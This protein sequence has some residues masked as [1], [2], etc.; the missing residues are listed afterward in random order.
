[1]QAI[2]SFFIPNW[3]SDVRLDGKTAVI[4]GANTGIG[5]ETAKDLAARGARVILA[6]RDMAKA[7]QAAKE[8]MREVP[9]PKVVVRHLDLSDTKS[10]CQFAESIYNSEKALHYLINNAGVA[11]CPYSTT[12]DG[13]EM[14]FGVNHLGHFF[15]TF[16]LLDLLKY[17]APSRVINLSSIAHTM[18]RIRFDD[19]AGEKNYNPVGAYAQSKLANVLFT[20]ELAK[21]TEA[22]GVTVYSVDPGVVNT[23]IARHISKP[24]STVIGMVASMIK[25]SAEGAYT[26]I[27]CV[28]TPESQLHNGGHYKDCAYNKSCRAGQDDATALKLW[29]ASCHL[30]SIR[31]R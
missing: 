2:R 7:E 24:L 3:S 19:L 5:K 23:E 26:T 12:V 21:R 9:C 25:T 16:L 30:L 29:A 20:R 1:M 17:S 4:T 27:Y 18:G 28:V 8:I 15:L 11:M 14:Q 22:L 10:I 6:C 13:F 31:W